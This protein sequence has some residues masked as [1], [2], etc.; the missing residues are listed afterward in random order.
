MYVLGGYIR[1]YGINISIQ[2][3]ILG[4]IFCAISTSLISFFMPRIEGAVNNYDSIFIIFQSALMVSLFSDFKIES[5]FI[6][7]IAKSSFG[8]YLLHMSIGFSIARKVKMQNMCSTGI[9]NLILCWGV[10][11]LGTFVLC[12]IIDIVIRFI[13]S[14]LNKAWKN[15]KIYRLSL[16]PTIN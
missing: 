6:N 2:Y 12:A 9:V 7:L 11:V 4:I 3:K 15:T 16:T 14:P 13:F 1:K 5:S 10:V 8:V